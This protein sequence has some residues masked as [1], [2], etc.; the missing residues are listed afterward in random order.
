MSI[1]PPIRRPGLWRFV[2]CPL[3]TTT[4]LV[5]AWK[6]QYEE[7]VTFQAGLHAFG[8]MLE[9]VWLG[10]AAFLLAMIQLSIS[11]PYTRPRKPR[12]PTINP[13]LVL[14]TLFCVLAPFSSLAVMQHGFGTGRDRAYAAVDLTRL[15]AGCRALRVSDLT[16]DPTATEA[17]TFRNDPTYNRLPK[18]LLDLNPTDVYIGKRGVI[19]KMDGGGPATHEGFFVP[20]VPLESD[21]EAMRILNEQHRINQSPPV[22]RYFLYDSRIL[23]YD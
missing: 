14:M 6:R 5:V 22:Y 11:L 10:P 17:G 7:G 12:D 21:P 13:L 3:L 20:L 1:A 23:P 15:V 4:L 19:V 8:F 18:E 9:L 2:L 16:N